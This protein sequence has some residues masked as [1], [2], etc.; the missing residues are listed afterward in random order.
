MQM[1]DTRAA[2]QGSTQESPGDF[3]QGA[4]R[5]SAATPMASAQ[6]SGAEAGGDY[7]N[8]DDDIPF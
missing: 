8:F 1:L 2:G 5:K 6:P 3:K 7:G 4:P